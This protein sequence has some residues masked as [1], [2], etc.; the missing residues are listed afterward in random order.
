M[1]FSAMACFEVRELFIVVIDIDI[2]AFKASFLFFFHVS[3]FSI[4]AECREGGGD[5]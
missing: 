2:C 3:F 5:G 4:F 1:L